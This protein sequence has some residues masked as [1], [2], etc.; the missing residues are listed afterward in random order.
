MA[1]QTR[2]EKLI[3]VLEEGLLLFLWLVQAIALFYPW[4]NYVNPQ[5]DA[6]GAPVGQAG[7]AASGASHAVMIMSYVF[8]LL[9]SLIRW[10]AVS[11]NLRVA[12]PVLILCAWIMLSVW[13]GPDPAKS[14]VGRFII[15]VFFSAYMASKYDYLQFVGFLTRG[16]A[17]SVLA[18]LAVILLVP[19]LGFSNIG[20][21]NVNAWRGAFTHKNWLGAAMS[22]GIIVS[23]YSYL[24]RVNRRLL[25]GATFL[26]CLFLLMMS[27]SATGLISTVASLLVAIV[28]GAVQSRRVPV[29]RV[30]GFICLGVAAALLVVLP[31]GVLDVGLKDLSAVVGRSSTLTGRTDLWRAVWAAIR[32]SPL[33]GHGYG[34]WEHPS[35]ARSNIWLASN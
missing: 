13:W 34:F 8:I 6:P 23:G 18:S 16:F 10:K 35:V 19:K 27:R 2:S 3:S 9:L 24:A 17:I 26:G 32:E 12:W 29:M 31:L 30:F 11:R 22:L 33:I 28:G 5:G 21:E 20:G 1:G 14:G 4:E 15:T 25:S 7:T